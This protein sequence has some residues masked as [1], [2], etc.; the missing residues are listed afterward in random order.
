MSYSY[1]RNV[2]FFVF[3]YERRIMI[4]LETRKTSPNPDAPII[5]RR[6]NYKGVIT[7]Q[8]WIDLPGFLDWFFVICQVLRVY[9]KHYVCIV[10]FFRRK[11]KTFLCCSYE[12]R[13]IIQLETRKT[14]KT[15]F[16]LVLNQSEKYDYNPNLVWFTRIP[17][18]VFLY[19]CFFFRH[20][21]VF[22]TCVFS[23]CF[24]PVCVFSTRE[25]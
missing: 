11:K 6:C 16:C 5:L 17:R 23:T 22:S 21:W 4:K 12:R 3:F 19:L 15:E 1:E 18:L 20:T 24:F 13:I 7:I 2:F 14:R 10:F 25:E 9:E 8:I